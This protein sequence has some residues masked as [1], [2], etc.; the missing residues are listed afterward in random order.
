MKMPEYYDLTTNRPT[1]V[2]EDSNTH[3]YVDV[4]TQIPLTIYYDANSTD[5][6]DNKG[7]IINNAIIYNSGQ[8]SIDESK[9][10]SNTDSLKIKDEAI[11]KKMAQ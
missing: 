10:I 6:F 11:K 7:R 2:M 4:S 9:V 3:Q 1:D 5:T 8:Y